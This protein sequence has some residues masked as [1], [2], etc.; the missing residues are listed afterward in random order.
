M[1]IIQMH[2]VRVARVVR[3][4]R[5]KHDM[6]ILAGP[7]F[8]FSFIAYSEIVG[9][10]REQPSPRNAFQLVILYKRSL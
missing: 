1:L 3:R 7:A 2:D 8:E 6:R 9:F 4:L 10:R 5:D